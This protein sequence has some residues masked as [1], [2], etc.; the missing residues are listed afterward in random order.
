MRSAFIVLFLC[1]SGVVFLFG[2]SLFGGR[3]FFFCV[4]WVLWC[5]FLS[6]RYACPSDGLRLIAFSLVPYVPRLSGT[7]HKAQY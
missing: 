6:L 7:R 3:L 5:G 1:L 4:L 2:F